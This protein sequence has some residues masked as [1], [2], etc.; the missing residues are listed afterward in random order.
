[1]RTRPEGT[2]C[3]T[4]RPVASVSVVCVALVSAYSTVHLPATIAL[5]DMPPPRDVGDWAS[6]EA[7]TLKGHHREESRSYD[8][9]SIERMRECLVCEEIRSLVPSSQETRLAW[10]CKSSG[11]LEVLMESDMN[12]V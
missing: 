4:H 3:M 5:L 7:S 11:R 2:F 6:F 1:M 9:T 10:H 8:A 12:Q